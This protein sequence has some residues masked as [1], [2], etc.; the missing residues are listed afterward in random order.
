LEEEGVRR[1]A[2]ARGFA[3][4][5]AAL[6]RG[7]GLGAGLALALLA[8]TLPA[9]ADDAPAV[10]APS[11][12][13]DLRLPLPPSDADLPP[14]AA[15]PAPQQ[16]DA[17]QPSD[18]TAPLPDDPARRS[19]PVPPEL[20]PDA[21]PLAPT[22]KPQYGPDYV[23]VRGHSSYDHGVVTVS[24]GGATLYINSLVAGTTIA[25]SCDSLV[26]HTRTGEA[27]L[28]GGVSLEVPASGLALQCEYFHYDPLMQRMEVQGAQ[29]RL[30]L[31]LLPPHTLPPRPPKAE[32]S[33]HFLTPTP[34]YVYVHTDGAKVDYNPRRRMFEMAHV[35]LTTNNAA[36]PDFYVEASSLAIG[37]DNRLELSGISVHMSGL[38]VFAWPRY[39]RSAQSEANPLT[40][41]FPSISLN[42]SEGVRWKQP[43]TFNLGESQIQGVADYSDEYGLLFEGNVERRIAP[44]L[45]LGLRDGTRNTAGLDRRRIERKDVMLGTAE[46]DLQRPVDWVQRLHL[47]FEYGSV[48]ATEQGAAGQPD[49]EV[50]ADRFRAAGQ[51]DFSPVPLGGHAY[52]TGGGGLS[53][54]DYG[55]QGTT[56]SVVSGEAGLV[57]PSAHD[58]FM[59]YI[60]YRRR[61]TDGTALMGFDE[62]RRQELDFAGQ[63]RLQPQWRQTLHGVYDID[64]QQFDTLELGALKRQRSYELGMYYDFARESAGLELGLRVD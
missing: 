13:P 47:N 31:S 12:A 51:L 55:G 45:V 1:P 10:A 56:Y 9:A 39:R 26:Y 5:G 20:A 43:V 25:V 48:S 24:G 22:T 27:E 19:L 64:K 50:S 32:F 59:N 29:V 23:D 33:G 15:L 14:F 18:A 53:Y 49:V 38:R 6:G 7:A 62:V 8:W 57:I 4:L 44:S 60:A 37:E 11:G 17:D 52:F 54:I 34:D 30:P 21:A 41:G 16:T 3:R 28:S 42:R 36:N 40:F 35:R 63:F 61:S 58:G 46:Y 2:L